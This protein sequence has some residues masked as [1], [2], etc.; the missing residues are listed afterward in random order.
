MKHIKLFICT[1]CFLFQVNILCYLSYA[2]L[3]LNVGT[4]SPILLPECGKDDAHADV[5]QNLFG[6]DD[7]DSN[8][9]HEESDDES[10]SECEDN[11]DTD[12]T[13]QPLKRKISK[14]PC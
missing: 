7:S 13:T 11:L 6:E 10:E 14:E 2:I 1:Y 3:F 12:S 9:K 8:S 5:E 4:V